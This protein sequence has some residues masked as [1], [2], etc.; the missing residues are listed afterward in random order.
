M[1]TKKERDGIRDF[2]ERQKDNDNSIVKV[3]SMWL[4]VCMN[5]L[6]KLATKDDE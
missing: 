1:M 2:V 4:L 3:M 6:D 5:E